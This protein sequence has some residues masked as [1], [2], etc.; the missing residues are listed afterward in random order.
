[1]I[2]KEDRYLSPGEEEDHG[3]LDERKPQATQNRFAVEAIVPYFKGF[4]REHLAS[5]KNRELIYLLIDAIAVTGIL[6]DRATADGKETRQKLL[7]RRELDYLAIKTVVF[8]NCPLQY[9]G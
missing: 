4:R 1:M 5:L 2:E 3:N 6:L 8:I 7:P 9:Q